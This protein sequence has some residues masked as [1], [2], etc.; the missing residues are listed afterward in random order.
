MVIQCYFLDN[1]DAEA[2]LKELSDS[3][4]S[5]EQL[6]ASGDAV[7]LPFGC[8]LAIGPGGCQIHGYAYDGSDCKAA[9]AA[10][11]LLLNR[12]SLRRKCKF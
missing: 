4:V 3:S 2:A 6:R 9:L 5:L 7:L 11:G 10:L 8:K 1:E 12:L